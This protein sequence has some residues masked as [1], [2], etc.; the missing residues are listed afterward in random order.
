MRRRIF[1]ATLGISAIALV[2]TGLVVA[3]IGQRIVSSQ[4]RDDMRRDAAAAEAILKDALAGVDNLDAV[5]AEVQGDAAERSTEI[6][7]RLANLIATARRLLD[8]EFFDLGV[9]T[10]TGEVRL[11]GLPGELPFVLD[12]T[13]VSAGRAQFVPFRNEDGARGLAYAQ[14]FRVGSSSL[15]SRAAGSAASGGTTSGLAIVLAR[16]RAVFDFRAVLRVMV[17]VLV[18]SI[19]LSALAARVVSRRLTRDLE[20][21]AGAARAL[22][23]GDLSVQAAESDHP[24]LAAVTTAFN[25]TVRRLSEAQ[26]RERAF[27]MSVGHELRTPLTTIAGYAEIL[28][29]GGLDTDETNRIAA[30]LNTEGARLR[31]LVE[32]LM[33]LARLEAREFTLTRHHVDIGEILGRLASGFED[34]AGRV[35]VR[36]VTEIE[37][38]ELDTDPDRVEQIVANLLE[39][40]LRYT[41]EAGEARLS[42]RAARGGGAVITVSDSG[43]G[44]D[45]DDVPRVFEKFYV[46]RTYRR[47]RPEG[48]GLGL[49]IVKELVDALGGTIAVESGDGGTVITVRL[50]AA[51]SDRAPRGRGIDGL[52]SEGPVEQAG[53]PGPGD[54][55]E[56]GERQRP[57]HPPRT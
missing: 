47:I 28:E 40:A 51:T 33:L 54:S 49:S 11:V 53:G 7:R 10:A 52:R 3:L 34:R 55:L 38:V 46:A 12:G 13:A 15:E 18:G 36:F 26:S 48:S 44:I 5:V 35:R 17:L 22:A 45:P 29:D 32:D 1:W 4:T 23:A 25:E 27:L 19:A 41:P 9:V 21:L 16:E 56:F 8:V 31:R 37:P 43:S 2:L 50:P 42:V 39:N 57:A 24:E 6:R 30:V 20:G 14:P